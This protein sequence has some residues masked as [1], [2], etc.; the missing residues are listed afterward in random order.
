MFKVH[1]FDF[2]ADCILISEEMEHEK[3]LEFANSL[4]TFYSSD[5]II[6]TANGFQVMS[7]YSSWVKAEISLRRQ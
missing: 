3:A 1:L 4:K 5:T 6:A 7:T 2:N